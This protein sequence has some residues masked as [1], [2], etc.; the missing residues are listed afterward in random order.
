MDSFKTLKMGFQGILNHKTKNIHNTVKYCKNFW[1]RTFEM[2]KLGTMS[3]LIS[4]VEHPQIDSAM[5][6]K[7]ELRLSYTG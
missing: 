2:L 6:L 4:G 5:V 1:Y 3:H 7:I